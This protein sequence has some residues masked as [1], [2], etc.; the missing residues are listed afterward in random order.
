MS[1]WDL[2]SSNAQAISDHGV[3]A[4]GMLMLTLFLTLLTARWPHR[5]VVLGTILAAGM[6]FLN[7][8]HLHQTFGGPAAAG[9]ALAPGV[10]STLA[11]TAALILG[12]GLLALVDSSDDTDM[13]R[14]VPWSSRSRPVTSPWSP[15]IA[16]RLARAAQGVTLAALLV[17]IG[18]LPWT[19]LHQDGVRF[20]HLSLWDL[21]GS[22]YSEEVTSAGELTLTLL[23]LSCLLVLV[24][25]CE[26]HR[27]T[28]CC[29]AVCLALTLA[30]VWRLH[31][32][33]N[34]LA[35]H[36]AAPE[37]STLPGQVVAIVVLAVSAVAVAPLRLRRAQASASAV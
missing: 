5:P 21:A 12:L 28:A 34:Q 20:E 30:S 24:V 13:A 36:R 26:P 10:A 2:P 16:R 32:V 6:S 17:G 29:V 11:G 3:S 8:M 25:A 14:Q 37:P 27:F 4:S 15:D 7:T 22:S 19:G 31:I 18:I 1:L 33:V 23:T 9:V 35:A